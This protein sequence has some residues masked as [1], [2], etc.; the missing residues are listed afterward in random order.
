MIGR[1]PGKLVLSGNVDDLKGSEKV[2]EAIFPTDA[3]QLFEFAND[4][5]VRRVVQNGRIVRVYART[6]PAGIAK[7]LEAYAPKTVDVVSLGLE[8]IFL[9]AVG[10]V[11]GAASIGVA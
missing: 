9:G 10:S 1:A 3:P 6:D 11:S 8:D 5:R 7:A 4:P 2:V